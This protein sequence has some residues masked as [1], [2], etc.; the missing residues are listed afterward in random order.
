MQSRNDCII[1]LLNSKYYPHGLKRYL[2]NKHSITAMSLT[3]KFI[4]HKTG[5]WLENLTFIQVF[6]PQTHKLY[7]LR[8]CINI[9]YSSDIDIECYGV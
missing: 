8:Q 4:P 3:E 6:K 9:I 1:L 5:E 2:G 7:I